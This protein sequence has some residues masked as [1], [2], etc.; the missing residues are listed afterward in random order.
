[1]KTNS[2]NFVLENR[3][4]GQDAL[5]KL[6]AVHRRFAAARRDGRRVI[7]R[8]CSLIDLNLQCMCFAQAHFIACNFTRA[9]LTDANFN[10]AQLFGSR[11]AGANVT[12]VSFE[13]ADLRAVVFDNAIGCPCR[14]GL[15]ARRA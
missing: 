12:R 15:G 2:T 6:A 4:I 1:M 8:N 11:F 9:D 5:A 7:L 3:I 13:R 14:T 10:G